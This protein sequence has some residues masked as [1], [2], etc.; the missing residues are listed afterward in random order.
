VEARHLGRPGQEVR[1][2]PP[3]RLDTGTRHGVDDVEELGVD[4]RRHTVAPAERDDLA[5]EEVGLHRSRAA[6]QAL[7]RGAA[8]SHPPVGEGQGRHVATAD[9]LLLFLIGGAAASQLPVTQ[10]IVTDN[11]QPYPV[12]GWM[13]VSL[14]SPQIKQH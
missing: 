5:V 2:T 7:P 10:G 9:L 1:C 4:R 11:N 12:S 3:A 14:V 13:E 8:A 6:L